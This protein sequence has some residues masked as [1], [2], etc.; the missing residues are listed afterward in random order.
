MAERSN[1][2]IKQLNRL[3]NDRTLAASARNKVREAARYI[4]FLSNE[5]QQSMNCDDTDLT[6]MTIY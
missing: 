3:A 5:I 2:V 6:N 4:E 1:E